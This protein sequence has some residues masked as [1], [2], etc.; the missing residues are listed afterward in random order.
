MSNTKELEKM[1]DLA[2]CPLPEVFYGKNYFFITFQE[3]DLLIE[4]SP[5]GSAS[6]SAF[7]KR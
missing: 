5:I 1:E 3:K 7:K 4:V 2:E 6:F